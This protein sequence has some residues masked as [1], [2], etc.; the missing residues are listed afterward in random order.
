MTENTI[1]TC[2][3]AKCTVVHMRD[4]RIVETITP[5]SDAGICGKVLYHLG[6]KNY[7]R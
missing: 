6:L 2:T 1:S 5:Y 3:E 4:G 7:T